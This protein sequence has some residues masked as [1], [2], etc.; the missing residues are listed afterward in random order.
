MRVLLERSP[1][2]GPL[3]CRPLVHGG[4]ATIHELPRFRSQLFL[5]D[6]RHRLMPLAAPGTCER[7]GTK[8]SSEHSNKH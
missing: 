4:E 2:L 5:R 6:E 8:N 7:R 3:E 1:D